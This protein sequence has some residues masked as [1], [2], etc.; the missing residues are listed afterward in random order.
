VGLLGTLRGSLCIY[1]GEELGLPEADVPFERLQDPYGIIFW[2]DYKGRDGCRTP[3]PWEARAAH[4]GFSTVEPW[5]PVPGEH[6]RLAVDEQEALADSVLNHYR[7]FIP[8]RN[9]HEV[10]RTGHI[11][12]VDA[13]EPLLAY[14]RKRGKVAMLI[15]VNM[16]AEPM[17]FSLEGFA[18]LK[19]LEGHGYESKVKNNMAHLCGYSAFFTRINA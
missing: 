3:M 16:G 8:W 15:V 19:V 10:L 5:L 1:Q 17:E 9:A 13:P 2:P 18:G 12:F 7:R 4:G 6:G 11:T 14:I